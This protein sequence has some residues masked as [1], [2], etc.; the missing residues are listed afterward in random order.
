MGPSIVLGES[1]AEVPL[2]NE[3]PLNHQILWQ[4]Y[5]DSSLLSPTGGCKENTS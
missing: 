4:Q 1:K 5:I 3:N 2:Q